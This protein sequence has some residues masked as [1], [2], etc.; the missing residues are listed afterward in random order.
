MSL[1]VPARPR[2]RRVGAGAGARRRARRL[3]A[4]CVLAL[5]ASAGCRDVLSR[6][7][8]YEEDVYLALDGSATIYVNASVPALVAL[9][10]APLPVDPRARLDRNDVRAFYQ[11]AAT[12]VRTVSTSRREGRRYVHLRLDVADVRRLG[13]AAPFAW[14]RY[15]F[16]EKDGVYVY[17]QQ[18]GAAAGTDV[19]DVGW[20]GDELVAI[21]LHLPSRVPFHNAPSRTIERGNI[22]VWEQPLQARRAGEP[23]AIEAHLETASILVRT[24][25]LFGLM[26]V[27]AAA[28]F[29]AFIWWVVRR[30]RDD[31]PTARSGQPAGPAAA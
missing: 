8:E 2:P 29:A 22:I 18:L 15:A 14:S 12:A 7:Y 16:T 28:A 5:V 25:S 19:G 31:D 11:T 4:A 23:L 21:R 26:I 3:L 13:E 9:R 6:E 17:A 10:Q 27:L 20:D 30:G 1:R 24:L